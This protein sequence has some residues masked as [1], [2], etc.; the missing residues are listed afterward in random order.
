MPDA[1]FRYEQSRIRETHSGRIQI[2]A[3]LIRRCTDTHSNTDRV[4]EARATKGRSTWLRVK[5]V[6]EFAGIKRLMQHL[7]VHPLFERKPGC[8]QAVVQED[9]EEIRGNILQQPGPE[10][11]QDRLHGFKLGL[12]QRA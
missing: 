6:V 12:F 7:L 3:W 9:L 8:W 1:A 10:L 2:Q 4:S 5:S 11:L